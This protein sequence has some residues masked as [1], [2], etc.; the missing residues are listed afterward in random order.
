MKIQTLGST[1]Y[2]MCPGCKSYHHLNRTI[3]TFNEDFDK[4]TFSPSV[5]VTT[6]AYKDA[7]FDIPASRC[8]SFV[9]E[10]RIEFLS[11]CSHKLAGQTIELPELPAI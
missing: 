5:L 10:G 2:F 11:D 6:E 1:L 9:R 8:H 7:D 3:W 4:P